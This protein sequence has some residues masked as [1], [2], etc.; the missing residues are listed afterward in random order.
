MNRYKTYVL[1]L[2][3]LAA[4]A[5]HPQAEDKPGRQGETIRL[6]VQQVTK[7]D[8]SLHID[9][10]IYASNL[11][12]GTMNSLR[13]DLFLQAGDK[14]TVLP[15]VVYA[16][17]QRAAFDKR[18]ES[19][20][21]SVRRNEPY[22]VFTGIDPKVTYPL[23]YTLSIPYASWMDHARLTTR[24]AF[25][26]CCNEHPLKEQTLLADINLKDEIRETATVQQPIATDTAARNPDSADYRGMAGLLTAPAEEIKYRNASLIAHIAYPQGV[27]KILPAF[28][29][30]RR[31]LERV[32]SLF[33]HILG[34]ELII[35]D[36]L[37]ITSYA[38]PEGSY[39]S[40]KLLARRRSESFM[41]Y[42]QPKY[43][44][45]KY[46]LQAGW[47]A[48]DWD[49]LAALVEK[50]RM[51]YKDEVMSIIHGTD[52]FDGREKKLMLLARGKPYRYMLETFFPR[53]RR[54]EARVF[55][56]VNKL[57]DEIAEQVYRTHPELLSM[58]EF[59]RLAGSYT[60]G[61]DNGRLLEIY[62]IAAKTWPDDA[63]ANN[64]AAAA[65]LINGEA[66]EALLYLDRI[67]DNP[68]SYLNRGV[69]YYITGD[70]DAARDYFNKAT[71]VND[72]CR[73][74]KLNLSLISLNSN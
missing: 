3:W 72:T 60:P 53:L 32:D 56:R 6:T 54:N 64:N 16:G 63:I 15:T 40:N 7:Q 17:K 50:S 19:V 59:C 74:A 25:H 24:E 20:D 43:N 18:K 22:R 31:E 5:V 39:A 73:Q 42:F 35:V 2:L 52:I 9:L 30:N 29:D 37:R 45:G 33:R 69:Y 34:N 61:A 67:K 14:Q 21:P 10:M 23:R 4:C 47:I 58:E 65:C 12:I 51:E 55:Y 38:S 70:T 46:A 57:T 71:L 66:T 62:R 28:R 13:L 48:E 36:T 41:R 1:L 44:L 68:L 49:G 27:H 8:D 26:D 11:H